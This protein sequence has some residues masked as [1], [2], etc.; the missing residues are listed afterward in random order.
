MS[1]E[2][3]PVIRLEGIGKKYRLRHQQAA[4]YRTLREQIAETARSVVRRLSGWGRSHPIFCEDFW[5]LRGISFAVERGERLGVIGR[6]GA[7]KSTLLKLLSR[8]TAPTEGR[9]LLRGRV[10]S[11]LE[12]G[13]GFHPELTGREN[14]FL[15]GAILGMRRSEIRRRFD[16]IVAFAEVEKF[17]D[18]PVKRYSSG[19][20]VR[21]AFAVAAHLDTEIL[22]V[23]EVL[24]VGDAP[25]QKK[26]LGKMEDVTR[27]GRTI[28]F[29]SHNMNAIGQICNR[30]LWLEGGRIREAGPDV[31]GIVRHYLF[32]GQDE[33]RAAG[34][35]NA[36]GEYVNPYFAVTSFRVVD[37]EGATLRSPVANDAAIA[38]Q[39][40]GLVRKTH[41]AFAVGY[42]L[43]GEGNVRL[44]STLITDTH[45]QDLGWL[46][47]GRATFRSPVP[48]RFLNN[49]TYRLA[50]IFGIKTAQWYIHPE[51]NAPCIFLT[52]AGSLG[53][54][55]Y[56]TEKRPGLIAP[57]LDWESTIT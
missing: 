7:G 45:F 43:Y 51:Q 55:P 33:A 47:E 8:I 26:C 23:D 29:I 24:A 21:L 48:K 25:F 44:Y 34:W 13:T 5:A 39:I 30:A 11:L 49:G 53:D 3:C 36:L 16:E 40:E 27:Q 6:N 17:L 1:S 20:Y 18:T 22:L 32:G 10:G 56:W 41:P 19:M 42:A 54:S 37:A 9:I 4:A 14:I 57:L 2:R 46:R 35:D 50:L 52:I 12:V 28:L 38:V 15:N 31:D